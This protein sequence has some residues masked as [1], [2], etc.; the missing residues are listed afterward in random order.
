MKFEQKPI[1]PS[2]ISQFGEFKC[3]YGKGVCKNGC[4][5]FQVVSEINVNVVCTL[6]K[7]A[8]V[9]K[10]EVTNPRLNNFL[11]LAYEFYKKRDHITPSE[12]KPTDPKMN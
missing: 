1:K 5:N 6:L 4:G 10:S 11:N 7:K 2:E 3:P 9:K 8:K 12:C